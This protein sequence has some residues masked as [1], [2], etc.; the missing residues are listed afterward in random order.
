MKKLLFAT[1]LSAVSFC[2][3]DEE[4]TAQPTVSNVT[5]SELLDS[6]V[7]GVGPA[8]YA[9][10]L[11]VTNIRSYAFSENRG[12]VRIAIPE[13]VDVGTCA[14]RGC[15]SLVEVRLPKLASIAHMTGA[16]GGC[17]LLSDVYLDGIEFT[18]IRSMNGYPWQV[19]NKRVVFHFKNGDYDFYGNKVN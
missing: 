4:I 9:A 18:N 14:F 8:S 11:F 2:R 6:F 19:P 16:F 12:I 5:E 15:C 13:A 1:I 3:A 7:T 10:S 17:I